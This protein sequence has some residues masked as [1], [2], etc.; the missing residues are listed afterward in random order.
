MLSPMI[1][2]LLILAPAQP[3]ERIA[4]GSCFKADEPAPIWADVR[5]SKPDAFLFLGDN[6]YFDVKGSTDNFD[7]EYARLDTY[8]EFVKLKNSIPFF[9]IWDDHDFGLNDAGVEYPRKAEAQKAFNKYWNVSKDSRRQTGEGIYD[10]A[11]VGPEGKRVQIIMLDTRYFRSPLKRDPEGKRGYVGDTNPESTFLGSAQWTWLAEELKKPAE[12]RLVMSSIQ[13]LPP[14]HMFEKWMNFPLERER[15]FKTIKDANAN[16]VIFLSGDRH[17]GELS[18][19]DAEVGYPLYDLTASAINRSQKNWRPLEA[20]SNR[21]WTVNVGNNFGFIEVD[22]KQADPAIKL[23]L[24]GEGNEVLANQPIRLSWLQA[25][26]I[27][28]K[29]P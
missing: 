2:S 29:K 16:G 10:S 22:W 8:P 15:L 24:R 21:V 26:K 13:V 7:K 3:L 4:M 14:D 23:Q 6:I 1:A 11:I 12:I 28:P 5:A 25:G 27:K 20:N 19:M 18:M 9:T 17:L